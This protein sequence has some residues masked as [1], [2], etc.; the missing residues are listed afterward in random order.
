MRPKHLFILLAGV[1]VATG[2]AFAAVRFFSPA[3]DHAIALV[4]KDAVVYAGAFLRPST[5]QRQALRDIVESFPASDTAEEAEELLDGLIAEVLSGSGLDYERDV[6]P[7]LGTEAAVYMLEPQAGTDPDAAL[8]LATEDADAS[9][10][11]LRRVETDDPVEEGAYRGID[12]LS[13]ENAVAAVLEDFVVVGTEEAFR[14]AVDVTQ[15]EDGSLADSS[16]FERGRSE[17]PDDVLGSFYIDAPA[18][19]SAVAADQG[20]PPVAMSSTFLPGG[21]VNGVL[22]ARTDELVV[23]LATASSAAEGASAHGT[24]SG[25]LGSLSARVWAGAEVDDLGGTLRA[26]LDRLG[27]WGGPGLGFA[28]EQQVQQQTG[29]RLQEDLLS[30]MAEAAVFIQETDPEAGLGGGMAIRS[31]DPETSTRVV[32]R[33]H[34]LLLARSKE[35]VGDIVVTGALGEKL[36]R[37]RLLRDRFGFS[38]RDPGA[39]QPLNLVAD[40]DR[41]LVIY[42]PYAT[43]DALN[44]GTPLRAALSYEATARSMDEGF[45][46]DAFVAVPPLLEVLD[47]FPAPTEDWATDV[48]P[49]LQSVAHIAFGSRSSNELRLHRLVIHVE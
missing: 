3:T 4:P 42:G 41:V 19:L 23:D 33:L 43:F 38:Y 47:H 32:N 16:R 30:W 10:D 24:G 20:R 27:A 11:A 18:L 37:K 49:N 36:D 2:A 12:F 21:P 1:A 40:G 6:R 5:A 46:L 26:L 31:T 25:M 7:W 22:S 48:K 9:W 13:S 15:E 45:E 35:R 28:L 17:L 39:D 29:L 8:L 34:G 14:A 44:G